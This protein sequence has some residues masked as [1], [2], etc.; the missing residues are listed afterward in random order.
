MMAEKTFSPYSVTL[1]TERLILKFADIN[2]DDDCQKILGSLKLKVGD[3]EGGYPKLG[4]NT[5]ADLRKR[6]S[7]VAPIPRL[8]T[9]AA[10]PPTSFFLVYLPNANDSI[11]DAHVSFKT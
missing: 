6:A 2:N 9:K 4:M 10:A 11:G 8:C 7:V 1:R 5:I 3:D